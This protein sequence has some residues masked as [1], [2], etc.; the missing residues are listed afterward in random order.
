MNQAAVSEL[1]ARL[2]T[3]AGLPRVLGQE[4]IRVW[5]LSG[6]ERLRLANGSTAVFKY[7]CR[8][9]TGENRVLAHVAAQG[10]P[11]PQV[12]AATVLDGMLGMILED[13]GDQA[14]EPTEHDAA[15][16]AVHL[17]ATTPAPWLDKLGEPELA[18]LPSQALACL[19]QLR[20]AGRFADTS[21]L[22]GHLTALNRMAWAR[23]T[24][25]AKPPV[26]PCHGELHPSALHLSHTGWHLLDFAM[27]FTGPGL[28]DLAA[29]SG[30]RR[31][32]DPPRTRRL[33]QQ[34]VR[35][36]GHRDALA[37]RGGLPAERWALGWHRVQAATWLLT[38]ATTGADGP[39]TDPRHLPVL[40]RQLT[41]ARQL[42][43]A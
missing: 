42:L 21:D 40:R 16:A 12:H 28:L 23:A 10:V 5:R 33:I 20:A 8:P 1:L 24:G 22:L 41:S 39:A 38:C 37:H 34:Y 2:V 36:G 9:F 7:A 13:L 29:W 14:R 6:V 35:S 4:P 27:A 32:A 30:L 11:V 26:G 15:S 18:A 31:P 25:A 43:A 19:E 17:H 3:E